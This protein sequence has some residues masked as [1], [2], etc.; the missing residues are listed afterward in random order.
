M[1]SG[2]SGVREK[3]TSLTIEKKTLFMER[4]LF[5]Y[6]E[7][8]EIAAV[9]LCY[10]T[11]LLISRNFH[12]DA[13]ITVVKLFGWTAL[14]PATNSKCKPGQSQ[15]ELL[16]LETSCDVIKPLFSRAIMARQRNVPAQKVFLEENGCNAG[17]CSACDVITLS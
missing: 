3:G 4:S 7:I 9:F 14:E 11:C 5:F 13:I 8:F 2:N 17:R 6:K 16:K 15:W 1:D 10:P 12:C